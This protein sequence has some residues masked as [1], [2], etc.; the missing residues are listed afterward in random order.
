[1]IGY[2]PLGYTDHEHVFHKKWEFIELPFLKELETISNSYDSEYQNAE[3]K[4]SFLKKL[5]NRIIGEVKI[6]QMNS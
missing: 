5:E 3:N 6:I 4:R 2:D 1:M